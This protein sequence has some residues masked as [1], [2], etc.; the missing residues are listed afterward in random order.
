MS[1][2]VDVYLN[3]WLKLSNQRS[4]LPAMWSRIRGWADS[5]ERIEIRRHKTTP[6][7]PPPPPGGGVTPSLLQNAVFTAWEPRSAL[8]FPGKWKVLLSADPAYDAAAR[9]AAPLLRAHGNRVG[10]WGNQQQI[11]A[12]RIKSFAAEVDA[13]FVVFQAETAAEYD[14]AIA[15]GCRY[16][17][18]NPNAW[19]DAQRQDATGRINRGELAFQ[20]EVYTNEGGPWPSG[21][22]AVGVPA[23]SEVIGVGWGRTPTGSPTTRRTPPPPCGRR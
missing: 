8:R 2:R 12:T 18:G 14:S 22:S 11:G 17:V 21:A 5:A 6:P 13:D 15:A 23:C 3:G 19:T 20:F 9:A 4:D 16:L 7:P 10:V 1:Q